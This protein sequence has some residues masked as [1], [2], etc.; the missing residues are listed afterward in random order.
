MRVAAFVLALSF[1]LGVTRSAE[2]QCT[3]N[4]S[5]CVSCHE[6]R[7]EMAVLSDGRP[8]HRDHGFGDLCA[9]CH[10]GDRKATD[11]LAAHASLAS[12]YQ[13]CADC[14][15][16]DAKARIATYEDC[17]IEKPK[18]VVSPSVPPPPPPPHTRDRVLV[19]IAAA[20]AAFFVWLVRHDRARHVDVLSLLRKKTWSPIGAGTLLGLVVALS[21]AGR[22][23]L[24]GVSGAFEKLAA[25]LGHAL[26]P[27]S[28]YWSHVMI[29]EITFGV[30]MVLGLLVGAFAAA[31]LSGEVRAR[32]LPDEGW[33]ERFGSRRW[34]R[35]AIAFLGAAIG[36]F[37]AGI[38]GGC[39]SGLAISGG[40]LLAPAAFLFMM[41]MFAGGIPTAFLWSRRGGRS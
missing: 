37:G 18:L 30:W 22:G 34:P 10:Q 5:S 36:Q 32:W 40:A 3:S 7:G 17:K 29:P 15:R 21:I 41:G 16:A 31:K 6:V 25:Y 8:W 4:A 39:T 13:S 28:Q 2:A 14:H 11:K 38:A 19:G 27:S 1:A 26:F 12:P 20:V 24:V 35:I 23:S 33:V 9:S